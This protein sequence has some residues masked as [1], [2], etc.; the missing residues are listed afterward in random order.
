VST[1][2]QYTEAEITDALLALVA[3]G[4]SPTKA[5]RS[6]AEKG[7]EIPVTT[8]RDWKEFTHAE[9]YSELQERHAEQLEKILVANYRERA[10][11]A[12]DGVELAIE[13]AIERL[14][15]GKDDDPA[16]TAAN[17]STVADKNTRNMLL[18][19]GRPTSIKKDDRD[20]METVR[21]LIAMGVIEP[22]RALEP[23]S[24]TEP[25]DADDRTG[26]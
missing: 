9:R 2:R 14:E 5:A 12:L 6:L 18:V 8:L 3:W 24:E 20:V 26:E 1:L 15:N 16:R 10:Y 7:V 11:H 4:G 21:S 17:L 13:K 22:P 23:G 19:D 25:A